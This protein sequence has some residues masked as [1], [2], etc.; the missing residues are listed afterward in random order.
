MS[1]RMEE[2]AFERA[3]LLM[4]KNNWLCKTTIYQMLYGDALSYVPSN[5]SDTY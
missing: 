3:L 1:P 5:I 4:R 2:R